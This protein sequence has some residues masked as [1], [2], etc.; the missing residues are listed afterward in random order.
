MAKGASKRGCAVAGVSREV[1]KAIEAVVRERFAGTE[2]DAVEVKAD[3]DEDGE[4]VLL[5][6]VVHGAKSLDARKASG[7]LRH[8]RPKIADLGEDAFPILSFI[9]KA[10]P[11]KAKAEAA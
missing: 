5:V 10:E 1:R 6:K 11:R 9:S 3:V 8:M 2:I 7:L 4:R